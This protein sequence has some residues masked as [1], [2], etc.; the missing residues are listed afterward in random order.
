MVVSQLELFAVPPRWLFLKV[1]TDEG[2]TGWGEPIVEGRV[3][4]VRAAAGAAPRHS[5]VWRNDDGTVAEW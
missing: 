1:S 3:A 4:T 5:P 2:I